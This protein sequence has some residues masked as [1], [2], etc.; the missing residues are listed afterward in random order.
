MYGFLLGA[1]IHDLP[2]YRE[3]VIHKLREGPYKLALPFHRQN[4]AF[5]P[6]IRVQVK[7]R[8]GNRSELNQQIGRPQQVMHLNH[9]REL[10]EY[11]I[12]EMAVQVT[13]IQ[14]Y[15]YHLLFF[16]RAKYIGLTN[17]GN[18]RSLSKLMKGIL[19]FNE[20]VGIVMTAD[21]LQTEI[22]KAKVYW[23]YYLGIES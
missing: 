11:N 13:D 8:S 20:S 6:D 19:A 10:D 9:D 22:Q 1:Y 5:T 18:D 15:A 17:G 12:P 4:M 2:P 21:E 16:Q 23:F 3:E 7:E 14:H